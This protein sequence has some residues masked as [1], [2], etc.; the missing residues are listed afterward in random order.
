MGVNL[1]EVTVSYKIVQ[2]ENIIFCVFSHNILENVALLTLMV[3][4][5]FRL[6]YRETKP[7]FAQVMPALAC[8][9][10]QTAPA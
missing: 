2:I 10:R 6:D 8:T 9:D 4:M 5:S 7:R 3:S 1:L